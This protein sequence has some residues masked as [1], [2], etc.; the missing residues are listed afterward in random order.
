LL[1][2]VP[3]E[4]PTGAV[5][6]RRLGMDAKDIAERPC[7]TT[8]SHIRAVLLA[9]RELELAQL[10]QALQVALD[11]RAATAG[12]LR[13]ESGIGKTTLVQR[14]L[15][16]ARERIADLVVLK[17]QCYERETVPY[18]ALDSLIDHLSSYWVQLPPSEAAMLVPREATLL[19]R[20]FPV[21]G[22]VP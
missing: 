21:L 8:A 3:E 12:L 13:G 4:R 7:L 20:L 9:G 5:M 6:L 11:S 15:D 19:S 10:D 1:S 17:G 2:R 14:F 22:R 16:R 18:Q